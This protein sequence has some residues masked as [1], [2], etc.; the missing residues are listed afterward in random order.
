MNGREPVHAITG[1]TLGEL[2]VSAFFRPQIFL[3][4]QV[5]IHLIRLTANIAVPAAQIPS[6]IPMASVRLDPANWH[7]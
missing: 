6:E 7:R 5:M 3:S 2:A 4:H 1:Y